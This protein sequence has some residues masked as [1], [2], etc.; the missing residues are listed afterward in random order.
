MEA[1][2]EFVATFSGVIMI[3][4]EGKLPEKTQFAIRYPSAVPLRLFL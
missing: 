2:T 3:P 1:V 4:I